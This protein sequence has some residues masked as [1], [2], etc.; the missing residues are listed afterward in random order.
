MH[1]LTENYR[2]NGIYDYIKMTFLEYCQ[3]SGSQMKDLNT[4][5]REHLLSE[6]NEG[7]KLAAAN[8]AAMKEL[9]AVNKS[10]AG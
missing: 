5:A 10:P 6:E 1:F 8:S 9:A 2:E 4:K 3:L 7:R